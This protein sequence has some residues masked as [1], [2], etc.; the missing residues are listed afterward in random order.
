MRRGT[1]TMN[2]ECDVFVDSEESEY[3]TCFEAKSRNG[4]SR[5]GF[6]FSSDLDIEQI[7][8]GI[9]YAEQ[10]GRDYLIAVEVRNYDG[11]DYQ[12]TAW[13]LAPELFVRTHE[14]GE[15]KV[16][17]DQIDQYGYCIGHDREY[18]IT[19]EAVE[20]ALVHERKQ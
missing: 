2:Q 12:K 11:S 20:S 7:E 15:K 5:P 8:S 17:W 18:T 6:Y 3:Y 4:E 16:S 10:S 9:E 1:F 19:H 14:K 13:L